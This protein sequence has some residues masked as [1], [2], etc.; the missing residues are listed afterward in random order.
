[1][2]KV[3]VDLSIWVGIVLV[4]SAILG[5]CFGFAAF[6]PLAVQVGIM[7]GVVKCRRINY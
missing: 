3:K 1:M 7:V 4:A 6:A 2:Q 5:L